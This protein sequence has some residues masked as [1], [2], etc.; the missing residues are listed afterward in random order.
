MSQLLISVKNVEEALVAR[1]ADVDLI[2]LKDPNVGA[3]GALNVH[4][5]QNIIE[6]L[7]GD[8]VVSATV[9][10]GHESVPALVTDIKRYANLGVDV[11]KIA[12]GN[13]FSHGDFVAEMQ[14][15]TAQGVRLVAVFFADE[16]PRFN[17]LPTLVQCGFYGAMLDTKYK[18]SALMSAL[19]EEQLKHF[20]QLC[21]QQHLVSGLAGSVNVEHMN[22]LLA[23]KPTFIGFRG[24]V[25]EA[26]DRVTALSQKKVVEVK[27]VLLN[28]NK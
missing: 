16:A 4:I 26:G 14:K 15:L 3:L 24:G 20:L 28:Y 13:L 22:A 2:D 10:E 25:C 1:Y 17:L 21:E 6:T 9:G 27:S 11:I 18:K 12:A 19:P 7:E 5:V 8:A 23:L